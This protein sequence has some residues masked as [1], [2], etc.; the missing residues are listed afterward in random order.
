MDVVG[1]WKCFSVGTYIGSS[2]VT[3]F[4]CTLFQE[5]IEFSEC[6]DLAVG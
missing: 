4:S 1:V 6:I 3:V 2:T 5:L